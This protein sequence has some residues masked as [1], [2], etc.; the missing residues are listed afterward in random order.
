MITSSNSCPKGNPDVSAP[1]QNSPKI[2]PCPDRIALPHW[3]EW[4][5]SGIH[6]ELIAAN[7]RSLDADTPY[8]YLCYADNLPRTNSGRL[9][10]Y[11]LRRYAHIEAGGWWCQGLDPLNDWAPMSWGCFKPD[12][13]RHD[14]QRGKTIKYEHPLKIPTRAFFLTISWKIGLSIAEGFGYADEYQQRILPTYGNPEAARAAATPTPEND[15]TPNSGGLSA[16]NGPTNSA[17]PPQHPSPKNREVK[18]HAD[19]AGRSLETFL[20]QHELDA[21]FWKWTRSKENAPVLLV[22]GAKKAAALLSRGYAAIAL[23]GVFNGRRVMRDEWGKTQH[24]SLIPELAHF[25]Q[26]GRPVYFCFDSDTKASTRRQVNLAIATTGKLLQ[27]AGCD[28]RVI[29]LP[30]PEKGVDDFLVAQGDAAF[31]MHYDAAL[32]L[33]LWQW[34]DR[35]Q[36]ELTHIP[37]QILHQAELRLPHLPAD[38]IL[39]LASAKGTGKT[40]AI[41]DLVQGDARILA[42]GHR[43]SLMRNLCDRM[44]LDYRND[45]DEFQGQA[46]NADGVTHR[47]GLCVDSLGKINPDEFRD[48]IV[49]ID[50]FMQVLRHLL[51]SQTCNQ[52]GKRP[53]LLAR[54]SQVIRNARLVILA[55]ADAADIGIDYIRALRGDDQPVH[56]IRNDFQPEGFPVRFIAAKQ[57]DAIV[58]EILEDIAAGRNIFIATD[59][60]GGSEALKLLIDNL[61]SSPNGLIIN[62]KTSSEPA[63]RDFITNPNANA[64]KYNWILATPSLATGVSIEVEHFEKVYGLFYGV[65]NDADAAQA[66]NRVRAKVSRTVWS[67]QQGKNFSPVSQSTQPR[68]IAHVLKQKTDLTAQVIRAS[69]ACPDMLLPELFDAVWQQNPHITLFTQLVAHTNQ[70]LWTLRDSLLARLHHEGNTIT[71]VEPPPTDDSPMKTARKQVKQAHFEAVAQAT[72][73]SPP[74]LD[75]IKRQDTV[76]PTDQLNIEKTQ[77]ADFLVLETVSASEVEFYVKYRTAV[78]RLEALLHGQDLA[79]GRDLDALTRQTQWG[80]GFLPFDL[81]DNELQRFVREQL[82][83]MPYLDPEATWSNADLQPLG[84][85]VRQ[86]RDQVKQILGFTISE[87]EQVV[88]NG[89]IFR[90]LCQQLGLHTKSFRRGGRGA[91]N[92]FYQLD[93]NHYQYVLEVADRRQEKRLADFEPAPLP[94]ASEG[95]VNPAGLNQTDEG[96]YQPPALVPSVFV[97]LM[98]VQTEKIPELTNRFLGQKAFELISDRV[99]QQVSLAIGG[100]RLFGTT[101]PQSD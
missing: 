51:L 94:I 59:S 54:L 1:P 37:T 76:S 50:E 23:P 82:G 10:P 48:G 95:V 101:K 15:R 68:A 100:L 81:P 67:V 72:I 60:L 35:K 75:Q 31:Q 26:P 97:E 22:E 71:I 88:T 56:L 4:L 43:I 52:D 28:V 65:I 45:L 84:D 55:D 96:N 80:H 70:S 86:H 11:I 89:W 24:E 5:D 46:I 32:P 83:L 47:V 98:S 73:L 77:V 99:R 44:G 13:P 6:P 12:T 74:K 57:D 69:L 61:K 14:A 30:G 49:V 19:I 78:L 39:V 85:R 66:L 93:G 16:G 58:A 25:A 34:Q 42:L 29:D 91:Q 7:L 17:R 3:Q 90:R 41:V 8:E 63:Q 20:D 38:G 87:N 92:R 64:H 79:I 21:N 18:V 27:D 53:A 2:V 33:P 9:A 40:K 36:S 62:S